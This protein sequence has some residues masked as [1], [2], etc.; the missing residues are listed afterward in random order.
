MTVII[1]VVKYVLKAVSIMAHLVVSMC[2]FRKTMPAQKERLGKYK[3]PE[4]MPD[5]MYVNILTAFIALKKTE[6]VL[7]MKIQSV[8]KP[9]IAE[10]Y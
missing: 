2:V 7:L 4:N 9:V 1:K 6:D 10:A 5:I 8:G 3:K